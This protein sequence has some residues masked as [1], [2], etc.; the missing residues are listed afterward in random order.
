[1]KYHEIVSLYMCSSQLYRRSPHT[2]PEMAVN[3]S[4]GNMNPENPQLTLL[5]GH[6]FPLPTTFPQTQ[7]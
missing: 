6:F 3:S 2:F 1:M 4:R 7:S 5:L